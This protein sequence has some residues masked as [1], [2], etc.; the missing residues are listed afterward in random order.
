MPSPSRQVPGQRSRGLQTTRCTLRTDPAV[1]RGIRPRG[2]RQEGR[3]RACSLCQGQPSSPA[4]TQQGRGGAVRR[5]LE[6]QSYRGSKNSLT[7]RLKAPQA[8]PPGALAGQSPGCRAS[9]SRFPRLRC[10]QACL[11]LQAQDRRG[12]A[13]WTPAAAGPCSEQ[14]TTSGQGA[15]TRPTLCPFQ[16]KRGSL[17][18]EDRESRTHRCLRLP[19]WPLLPGCLSRPLVRPLLNI[20]AWPESTPFLHAQRKAQRCPVLSES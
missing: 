6:T 2:F 13:H 7:T 17:S 8:A 18:H 19:F 5:G 15:R 12:P 9:E 20:Q 11:P 4:P 1:Q 14:S 16:P 3:E 10:R